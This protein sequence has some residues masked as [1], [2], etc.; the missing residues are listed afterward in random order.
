MATGSKNAS[1]RPDLFRHDDA[2]NLSN[3]TADLVIV[4]RVSA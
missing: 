1:G 2:M 3:L 4:G